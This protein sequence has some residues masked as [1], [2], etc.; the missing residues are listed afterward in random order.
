MSSSV[1]VYVGQHLHHLRHHR[2]LHLLLE[3]RM[4]KDRCQ[5][6]PASSFELYSKSSKRHRPILSKH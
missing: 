5:Y 2:L 6:H 1:K 3:M 4:M